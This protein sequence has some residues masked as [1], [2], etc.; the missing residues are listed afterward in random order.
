MAIGS[1]VGV[2]AATVGGLSEFLDVC[3]PQFA[4]PFAFIA[5]RGLLW[6]ADHIT[7]DP[8]H[9]AQVGHAMAGQEL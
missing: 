2:P 3:R 9:L 8:I 5:G 7:E 6:A 4:E 1:T